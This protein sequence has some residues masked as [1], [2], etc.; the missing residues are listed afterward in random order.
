MDESVLYLRE[1]ID[2]YIVMNEERI[3]IR[4]TLV[5]HQAVLHFDALDER[6][7]AFNAE[8]LP[9]VLCQRAGGQNGFSGLV[10][11]V[12]RTFEPFEILGTEAHTVGEIIDHRRC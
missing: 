10:G 1:E 11:L 9:H 4:Q 12:E 3:D 5:S 2:A 7:E 6:Q 8:T